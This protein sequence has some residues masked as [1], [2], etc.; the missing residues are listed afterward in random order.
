MFCSRLL[1]ASQLEKTRVVGQEVGLG[2]VE[3]LHG[4]LEGLAGL[5]L[6]LLLGGAHDLLEDGDELRS[7]LLDGGVG[8][9]V[10]LVDGRVD[11]SVL[12]V[13]LLEGQDV[14]DGGQSL[15]NE[16]VVGVLGHHTA[17]S[18]GDVVSHTH[19]VDGQE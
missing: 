6:E 17:E 7:E 19:L 15:G 5:W 14:D 16:A 4:S 2:L 1:D 8:E 3:D 9:L 13:V 18:T 10:E 12:L 11:G